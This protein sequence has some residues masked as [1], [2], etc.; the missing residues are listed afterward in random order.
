MG[1]YNKDFWASI[2]AFFV[3]ISFCIASFWGTDPDVYLF[4]RIIAILLCVLAIMQFAANVKRFS[5]TDESRQVQI[6]WKGL[7]P[8]LGASI[9]YVLALEIVGFYLSAFLVFIVLVSVYGKRDFM[10][11]Q[12]LTTK[13]IVAS[14][15]IG[16][17]YGLFWYLLNVRTPTGWVM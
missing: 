10:D 12:A 7:L 17:L 13:F 5:S 16:V 2:I 1:T 6:A 11:K 9:V 3:S 8:G 4:P 15:I 14:I